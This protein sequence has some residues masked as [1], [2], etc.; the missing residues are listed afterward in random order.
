MAFPSNYSF[1]YYKGDTYSF[2]VYPKDASGAAFILTGYTPKFT[3]AESRGSDGV[4]S[5]VEAYSAIPT[6]ENYV[7]CVIRP[8]DGAQLDPTK[9]YVYDVEVSKTGD[10]YNSVYTLLTGN[11]TI[12]D[13][14]T[15]AT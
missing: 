15:G 5:Q 12:T 7:E 11:I 10:S 9:E 13:Q 14:V 6:G 2:L 3:I 1:S 4:A 8:T